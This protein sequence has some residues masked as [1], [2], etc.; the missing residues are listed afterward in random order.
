MVSDPKSE[1]DAKIGPVIKSIRV[2]NSG[3]AEQHEE[4]RF[5]TWKPQL[6]WVL[7]SRSWVKIPLSY[8]LIEHRKGPILF[9]TG[10]DPAIA[11]DPNY[12]SVALG[13]FLF[14]RIFR[15]HISEQD[16]LDR[17]VAAS[18]V[19]AGDIRTAVI[20]HLHFDHVGGITHIPQADL[21]VSE[22]E[23]AQLSEPHP[24]R[25]WILR[26]HIEIPNAK[27]QPVTFQSTDD[28]LF[29]GFDGIFDVAGDE[30]MILFPTPGHTPG[31][32]SML[33]RREGWAP[34]LLAGDLTYD[35][36]LLEQDV[37][38]GTGDPVVLRKSFAKVHRLK[39]R[40]PDLEVVAAHDFG[41][42]DAIERATHAH[43]TPD[44]G[45][46]GSETAAS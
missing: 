4:H 20:S 46:A 9:D 17:V 27:W 41:A 35:P 44:D 40:L 8:V 36:K 3:W 10:L 21:L 37:T 30:S 34:I 33:I 22:R 45:V 24:E 42:S 14:R 12:I 31:S 43:K 29:E 18:G 16:R 5:G 13:R 19:S 26:E 39:E 38:P 6:W 7:M 2:L 11:S 23:W 15:V 1:I 32:M 25:E 28:P